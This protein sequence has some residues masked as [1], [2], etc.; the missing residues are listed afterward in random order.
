VRRIDM[1]I[2]LIGASGFVGGVILEEALNRGHAVTALSRHPEKLPLK[3]RLKAVACDIMHDSDLAK[4]VAGHDIVISAYNPGWENP[5]I[6]DL[7]IKGTRIIID[8]AKKAAVKRLLVVG[9]AGSLEVKPGVQL[10][11]TPEFPAKF[12]DGALG[13]REALNILKK[14]TALNWTFVSPSVN[15]QPGARTAKFRIGTD[16]VLKD[17]NGESNI[18]TQDLAVAILNECEKPRFI[19]K[20]FTAGY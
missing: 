6:L 13:A 2:A 20:R 9:G 10:V 3:P 17:E 8:A 7:T 12:K 16:S 18:S 14:E 5:E 11:D 15:L 1:K 4:A 19:R